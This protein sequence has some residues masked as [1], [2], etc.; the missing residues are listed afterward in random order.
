MNTALQKI[1]SFWYTSAKQSPEPRR[2]ASSIEFTKTLRLMVP[3][4]F[5]KYNIISMF[6]SGCNDCTWASRW[7]DSI[8]YSGGDISLSMVSEAWNN[9]PHLDVRLHDATTDPFP[10]VDVIFCRDVAIHL[11]NQDKRKLLNNWISSQV[12]WLM[13]TH[14]ET[15]TSNRDFE[16]SV[17]SFPLAPVNWCIDPWNFPPPKDSVYEIKDS[18]RGR[19]MALWHRDQIRKL[20]CL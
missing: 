18:D 20:P 13:I 6:D 3:P 1:F 14:D 2:G 19:C 17:D 10:N 12:S 11:N 16:Y 5:K 4:L 9:F 15:L 8:K 7:E